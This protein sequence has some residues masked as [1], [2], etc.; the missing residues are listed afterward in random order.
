MG[1]YCCIV[2]AMSITFDED[3]GVLGKIRFGGDFAFK[4]V[5]DKIDD[6]GDDAVE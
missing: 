5:G 4:E 1:P 2:L 3:S 6:T